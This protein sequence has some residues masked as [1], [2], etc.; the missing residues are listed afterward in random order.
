MA[1]NLTE[2]AGEADLVLLGRDGE[3]LLLDA[4]EDASVLVLAGEPID[5]PVAAHGPFVRN[6]QEELLRAAEDYRASRMGRLPEPPS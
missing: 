6:T 1:L 5:E 4:R 2:M 3:G